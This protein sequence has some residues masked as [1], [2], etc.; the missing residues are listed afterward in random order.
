LAAL[1]L[2][3]AAAV[4]VVIAAFYAVSRRARGRAGDRGRAGA[5][6]RAGDRGGFLRLAQ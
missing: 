3:W 2:M 6:G 4:S 5:R 1:G